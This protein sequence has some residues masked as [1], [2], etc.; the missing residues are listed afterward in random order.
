MF[1]RIKYNNKPVYA[2]T[3]QQLSQF[4]M[5]L[6]TIEQYQ[7]TTVDQKV[8]LLKCILADKGINTLDRYRHSL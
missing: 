1:A 5:D 6:A 7:Q 2:W 4:V 8:I 3:W